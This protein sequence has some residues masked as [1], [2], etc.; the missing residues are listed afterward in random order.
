[1]RSRLAQF[2][3]AMWLFNDPQ[4]AN[5]QS[6]DSQEISQ[7]S[8]PCST[9]SPREEP[10]A[11][12]EISI[13]NV[14]FSGFIQMPVSDQEDIATAVKRNAHG[15]DLNG[16]V[17]EALERVKAGWQNRGYFKVEVSGDARPATKT[18]DNT[19]IALFVH[20]DENAQYKL[21]EITF[22]NNRAIF[23]ESLRDMFRIK[24]GDIFSREKI[25]KGLENLRKVY[26]E[27]GYINYTG[28]PVTTFDE[29][30]KLA[31]LEIDI[32]EGKQFYVS[33]IRL[34]GLDESDRKRLRRA[35]YLKPGE[36]YNSRLWELSQSK[37]VSF[38]PG[39]ECNSSDSRHLDE[40]AGT[41]AI[42][43]DLRPCLSK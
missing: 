29:E 28:V 34:E 43:L 30:H 19:Q 1:M 31:N 38:F 41:V 25:A 20:V 6:Q 18:G 12:Q 21:H 36:I 16:L 37:I 7:P 2:V 11:G 27:F 4:P 22:K 23:S 13:S 39:C 33:D 14:T 40:Q 3:L 32:D 15:S 17:E 10:P 8:T 42:T 5:A 26:G 35:L 9:K 24:D